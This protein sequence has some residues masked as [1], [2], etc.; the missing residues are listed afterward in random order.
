MQI[1]SGRILGKALDH[2]NLIINGSRWSGPMSGVLTQLNCQLNRFSISTGSFSHQWYILYRFTN[3]TFLD[4]TTG[5]MGVG[6]YNYTFK[7]VVFGSVKVKS[8]KIEKN[9]Q[10]P[11][12]GPK[13][14]LWE[15]LK[16]TLWKVYFLK[17]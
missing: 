9:S 12:D 17:V 10:K 1:G 13:N 2:F 6:T 15:D 14:H 16:M 5:T 8:V 11:K 3:A 4:L 7:S